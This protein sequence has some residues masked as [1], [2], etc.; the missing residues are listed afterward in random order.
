[1]RIT[2]QALIDGV[3][4][5]EPRVETIGVVE[6]DTDGAPASGLGLFLRET[7]AVLRQLQAGL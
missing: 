7:H 1:M 5:K 6:R 2:I 4:R 3:E